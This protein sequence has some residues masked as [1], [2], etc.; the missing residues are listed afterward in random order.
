MAIA[1]KISSTEEVIFEKRGYLEGYQVVRRSNGSYEM[2][3]CK[4]DYSSADDPMIEC[5]GSSYSLSS[6]VEVLGWTLSSK[7]AYTQS[8]IKDFLK[9]YWDNHSLEK[10]MNKLRN[11]TWR[12]RENVDS[13]TYVA[14]MA[15]VDPHGLKDWSY[16]DQGCTL[17]E[18]LLNLENFDPD[19]R[20]TDNDQRSGYYDI[21]RKLKENI[22]ELGDDAPTFD[23]EEPKIRSKWFQLKVE[24]S[25]LDLY[26]KG[27]LSGD[28][29][30]EISSQ[31]IRDMH[32]D[33][34]DMV[35]SYDVSDKN[36]R[37]RA[38]DL[39]NLIQKFNQ[40]YRS[41]EGVFESDLHFLLWLAVGGGFQLYAKVDTRECKHYCKTALAMLTYLNKMCK[42]YRF[43]KGPEYASYSKLADDLRDYLRYGPKNEVILSS[44]YYR[45]DQHPDGTYIL[46]ARGYGLDQRFY[47]EEVAPDLTGILIKARDLT[48]KFDRMD[49]RQCEV[50]NDLVRLQKLIEDKINDN[51]KSAEYDC[52]GSYNEEKCSG[53]SKCL[54][55]A[56]EHDCIKRSAELLA[57]K[58]KPTSKRT[59]E[60]IDKMD[61]LV[62]SVAAAKAG[63]I[64]G[65]E[66]IQSIDPVTGDLK[67][68]VSAPAPAEQIEINVEYNKEETTMAGN[69]KNL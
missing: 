56:Y 1:K 30:I 31:S 14:E 58:P 44:D 54:I 3:H 27:R 9:W 51:S 7:D 19:R 23:D 63:M 21:M 39:M 17:Y 48:D 12:I 26:S 53:S 29:K 60:S 13:G 42:Q 50:R 43:S 64:P 46:M 32:D 68:S 45:V 33:L 66:V 11:F 4:E 8:A 18:L 34:I 52:Y 69:K 59:Q 6:L 65:A 41:S 55:C 57:Q 35:K 38:E 16:V 15:K 10:L 28:W 61:S 62:Y 24:N 40:K 25:V 5:V 22:D 20:C 2:V 36:G 67:I 37:E 47:Q 49:A